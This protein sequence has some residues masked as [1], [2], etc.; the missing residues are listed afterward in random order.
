MGFL[1]HGDLSMYKVGGFSWYELDSV[2]LYEFS[3]PEL[4]PPPGTTE[5]SKYL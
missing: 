5:A 2:H 3:S 4:A 1:D